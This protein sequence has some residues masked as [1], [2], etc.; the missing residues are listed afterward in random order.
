MVPS[1]RLPLPFSPQQYA[2]PAVVRAHAEFHPS[3]MVENEVPDM[4]SVGVVVPD[5]DPLPS[6][7]LPS[8]PQQ[9]RALAVVSPQAHVLPTSIV[10]HVR[11]P[12]TAFGV[13]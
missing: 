6:C 8:P 4:I 3:E 7:P 12:E 1:P 10:D 5:V 2:A 11:P 13:L 9:Y